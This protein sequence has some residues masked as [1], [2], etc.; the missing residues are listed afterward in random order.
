MIPTGLGPSA[1][2]SSVRHQTLGSACA[3]Q[4]KSEDRATRHLRKYHAYVSHMYWLQ[5]AALLVFSIPGPQNDR[6]RLRRRS[7]QSEPIAFVSHKM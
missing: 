2:C 5:F 1:F 4:D 3:R 6:V 7:L